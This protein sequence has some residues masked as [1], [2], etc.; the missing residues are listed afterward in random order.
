MS[1]ELLSAHACRRMLLDDWVTFFVAWIAEL[2]VDCDLFHATILWLI[3]LQLEVQ[4]TCTLL[5][6]C[7]PS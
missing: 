5:L 3:E 7:S 4:Q 2:H 1:L 6:D